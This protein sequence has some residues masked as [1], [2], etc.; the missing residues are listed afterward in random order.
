MW[1]CI[2]VLSTYR[3]YKKDQHSE[4]AS[5]DT[6]RDVFPRDDQDAFKWCYLADQ[7]MPLGHARDTA[8]AI[9]GQLS[10]PMTDRQVDR[11][12]KLAADWVPLKP[13]QSVL[14]NV[15]D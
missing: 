13:T 6:Q 10:D 5:A 4:P 8:V 2:A 15:E 7:Y 1:G 9:L 11:A 12:A 3:E 14:G